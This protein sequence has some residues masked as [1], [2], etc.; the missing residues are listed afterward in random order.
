ME[1][2]LAQQAIQQAITGNW[3]E[4]ERL[5]QL[6][7]K[8]SPKD[9][10]AML[11]LAN[12]L[13]QLQKKKEATKTY[14]DVLKIDKY[15]VF[16]LRGLTKIKKMKKKLSNNNHGLE[17]LFLEEPGKTKTIN[18]VHVTNQQILANLDSGQIVLLVP[19]KHRISVIAENNIYVGRLPDDLSVRI[20]SFIEGGNQYEAVIKSI[21]KG[22]VKLFIKEIKRSEKF[23]N[24][25][26]FFHEGPLVIEEYDNL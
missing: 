6:I 22:E 13:S 26:S 16:A 4:A 5:N 18:L 23:G 2:S 7:L 10:E 20:L 3:Q 21:N 24:T 15:N 19:R 9:L 1:L 17:T 12:A 8:E 11:R 25:P 14:E